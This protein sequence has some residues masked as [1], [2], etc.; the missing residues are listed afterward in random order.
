MEIKRNQFLFLGMLLI[1][2]GAHF[3]VIE[4]AHLNPEVSNALARQVGHPLA[5]VNSAATSLTADNKSPYRHPINIP[6]RL[7][8]LFASVGIIFVLHAITV[9]PK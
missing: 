2:I 5:S 7:G 3:R 9:K 4:T 1:L 8:W 6:N